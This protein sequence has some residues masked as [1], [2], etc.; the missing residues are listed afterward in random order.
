MLD[1]GVERVFVAPERQ[2]LGLPPG[3][4]EV[5]ERADV[6]AGRE[7]P[8]AGAADDDA[9]DRRIAGPFLELCG[10][11]MH[12]AVRH[13]IERLR[14]VQRNHPRGAASVEHD[15]RVGAQWPAHR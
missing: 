11:R 5:V 8:L 9:G 12:H 13:R 10:Q 4:A 15:V 2:R 3:T 7:R 6:A 14:A 1:E